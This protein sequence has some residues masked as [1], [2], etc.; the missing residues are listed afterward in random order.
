MG[1][2]WS[3]IPG[4]AWDSFGWYHRVETRCY[5]EGT[6]A[7]RLRIVQNAAGLKVPPQHIILC[8]PD[9]VEPLVHFAKTHM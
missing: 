3:E 9:N 7:S 1:F 2:A 6:L 4:Q 8:P 5:R